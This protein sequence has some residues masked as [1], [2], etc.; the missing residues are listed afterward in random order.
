M[1]T[2]CS[3]KDAENDHFNGLVELNMLKYYDALF[4]FYLSIYFIFLELQSYYQSHSVA[5]I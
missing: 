4:T 1:A 3:E 2:Y 5:Q